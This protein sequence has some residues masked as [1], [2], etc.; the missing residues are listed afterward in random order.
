MGK[1]IGVG[2]DGSVWL[3]GTDPVGAGSDFGVCKWNGTNW[4]GVGGGGV[5]IAV[6]P[7]GTPWVV[8]SAGQIFHGQLTIELDRARLSSEG[9][10]NGDDRRTAFAPGPLLSITWGAPLPGLGKDIGVGADGSVWLIGTNPVG[11]GSDFGVYKWN[12]TN[13]DGLANNGG[14]CIAVGPGGL[15]WLVNSVGQI[16]RRS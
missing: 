7:D 3:I 9:V 1:D 5:R 6:G 14:V 4:D 12:G 8:N 16:F 15:A 2:A 10:V 13:W 11:A